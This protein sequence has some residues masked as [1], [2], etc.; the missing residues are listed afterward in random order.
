M[1]AHVAPGVYNYPVYVLFHE[2]SSHF[3]FVT[4]TNCGELF[5]IDWENPKTK[6]LTLRDIAAST[7]CPTC[8]SPLRDTLR[9]YPQTIKLPNGQ[10]GSFTPDNYIPPDNETIIVEFFEIVP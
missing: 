1:L 5:V 9:D 2:G 3:S 6:G 7:N 8:N 4:C 10:F